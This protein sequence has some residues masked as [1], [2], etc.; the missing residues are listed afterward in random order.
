MIPLEA[1]TAMAGTGGLSLKR[2]LQRA[3]EGATE[4]AALTLDTDASGSAARR[5]HDLCA[6][7]RVSDAAARSWWRVLL[8]SYAKAD[9]VY[10]GVPWLRSYT[11]AVEA[12]AAAAERPLL[13][14]L[15]AFFARVHGVADHRTAIEEDAPPALLRSFAKS[16]PALSAADTAYAADLCAWSDHRSGSSE[17]EGGF[18][19]DVGLLRRAER[20]VGLST[21]NLPVHARQSAKLL[22]ERRCLDGSG[23]AA[24][25]I[26]SQEMEAATRVAEIDAMLAKPSEPPDDDV[27]RR[28]LGAER[29]MLQRLVLEPAAG[30]ASATVATPTGQSGAH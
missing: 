30:T 7:L 5:W 21:G 10:Y 25:S 14:R 4:R 1:E 6:E 26:G 23:G 16:A 17:G 13:V 22:L 20:R 9:R 19:A 29:R 15:A 28:N 12:E 2:Q 11:G 27:E 8:E 24:G 18:T 3:L